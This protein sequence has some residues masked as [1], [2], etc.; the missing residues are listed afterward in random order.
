MIPA[1][2]PHGYEALFR[3]PSITEP[4]EHVLED[5]PVVGWNEDGHPLVVHDDR[6]VSGP[7]VDGYYGVR[8]AFPEPLGTV[9]GD[10][11]HIEVKTEIGDWTAPV[12]AWLVRPWGL[13]TP[14]ASAPDGRVGFPQELGTAWRV[15]HPDGKTAPAA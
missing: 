15:W 2:T 9:P 14:I 1:P 8:A 13:A 4:G 12:I 10:G 6:L 11:W 3:R 5:V 7:E